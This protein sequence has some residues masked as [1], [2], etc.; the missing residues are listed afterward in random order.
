MSQRTNKTTNLE[1]GIKF[2]TGVIVSFVCIG[3]GTYFLQ[4]SLIILQN[5]GLYAH[6]ASILIVLPAL[7]G[8]IQHVLQSPAR[9]P[10]SFLGALLS[11]SM[12]YPFYSEKFWATPPSVTDTVVFFFAVTGIGFS[13]SINPL[14]RHIHSKRRTRSKKSAMHKDQENERNEIESQMSSDSILNSSI[15]KSFELLLTILSFVI[16]IWGTFFL[17]SASSQ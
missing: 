8:L 11:T 3:F 4:S 14:D 15:I 6:W 17:G 13:F 1:Q 9:L 5:Y 12:L 16:A 7:S 10:L 2:G